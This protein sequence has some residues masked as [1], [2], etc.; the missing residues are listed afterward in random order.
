MGGACKQK[1]LLPRNVPKMTAGSIAVPTIIPLRIPVG[2]KHVID[3]STKIELTSG[4]TVNILCYAPK[5]AL[6]IAIYISYSAD[7]VDTVVFYTLDGTRPQPAIR[8]G[9]KP[10][11]ASNT[12]TYRTPF[13][14]GAG[15]VCCN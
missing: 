1:L 3:T 2:P 10:H 11:R 6:Y 5:V 13:F 8:S 15:K 9:A 7:T 14:L 4:E 12:F